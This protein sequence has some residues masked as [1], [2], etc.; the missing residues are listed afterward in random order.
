MGHTVLEL[1]NQRL[2]NVT[3][4]IGLSVKDWLGSLSQVTEVWL[5]GT[6]L[7]LDL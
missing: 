4:M 6:G 7:E 5:S 1:S 2:A 3:E